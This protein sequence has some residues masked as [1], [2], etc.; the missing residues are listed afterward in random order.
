M[1]KRH[2]DVESDGFYGAY[3]KCKTA[4]NFATRLYTSAGHYMFLPAFAGVLEKVSAR[5]SA[6]CKKISLSEP[7]LRRV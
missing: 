1:K 4:S 7:H 3:W 5:K 6:L 2:F